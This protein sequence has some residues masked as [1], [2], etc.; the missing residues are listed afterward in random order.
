MSV[1]WYVTITGR[2]AAISMSSLASDIA[3]ECYENIKEK[4]TFVDDFKP[5]LYFFFFFQ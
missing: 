2:I 4:K 1:S 3:S 5:F